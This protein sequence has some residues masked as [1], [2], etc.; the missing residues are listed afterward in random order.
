MPISILQISAMTASV[1][2]ADLMKLA[3]DVRFGDETGHR[4]A[5]KVVAS[6]SRSLGSGRTVAQE[7]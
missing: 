3:F 2:F 6:W 7:M 4:K 1:P 5:D